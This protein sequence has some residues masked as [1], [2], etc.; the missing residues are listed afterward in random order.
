[1]PLWGNSDTA[2]N[3]VKFAGSLINKAPNANNQAA[4]FGNTTSVGVFGVDAQESPANAGVTHPGWILRTVGSG[5]RAGRVFNETLVAMGSMVVDANDDVAFKDVTLKITSQPSNVAA[6][7]T[8]AVAFSVSSTS[9]PNT[10]MTYKWQANT[11]SGFVDIADAGVYS[12]T[13][14][15][16]LA[17]S[18]AAGLNGTQYRVNISAAGA[19][20]KTSRVAVLTV[21]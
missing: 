3:S 14:T 21:S 20:T 9:T 10:A 6:N 12:N 7:S 11:G 16:A 4:M 15:S 2:N 1:M 17:I 13:A 19:N 18:S 8:S 5:G